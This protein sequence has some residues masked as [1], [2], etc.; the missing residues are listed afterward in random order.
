MKMAKL[1]SAGIIALAWLL[2]GEKINTRCFSSHQQALHA[3]RRLPHAYQ[4]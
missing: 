2:I 4:R 1:Q 3:P